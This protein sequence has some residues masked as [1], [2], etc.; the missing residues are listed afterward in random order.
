MKTDR[1][2]PVDVDADD[3]E[4]RYIRIYPAHYVRLANGQVRY[5]PAT[6]FRHQTAEARANYLKAERAAWG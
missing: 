5:V 1:P 4:F 6:T 3:G 2:P